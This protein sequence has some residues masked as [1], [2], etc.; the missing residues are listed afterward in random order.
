MHNIIYDIHEVL[1][2]RNLGIYAFILSFPFTRQYL[3]FISNQLG[4][5][6]QNLLFMKTSV[7]FKLSSVVVIT[8]SE[9]RLIWFLI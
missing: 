6:L 2:T 5:C 7:L 1:H 9:L 8:S 4:H 3:L